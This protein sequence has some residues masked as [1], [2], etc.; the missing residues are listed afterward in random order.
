[1]KAQ[2]SHWRFLEL[3]S[4]Q[5]SARI[6]FFD[7]CVFNCNGS[8]SMASLYPVLTSVFWQVSK[9]GK[10]AWKVRKEALDE[11]EM[12]LKRVTGLVNASGSNLKHVI[13]LTRA[14]R[15]RL[16]DTQINLKPVA[17]RA[18]AGLLSMV[19]KTTQAKLGRIVFAP[20]INAAMN[21]I[22]KPM[23]DAALEALR[24]GTTA[25]ELLGGGINEEALE[26]FIAALV[27]EVTEA[28]ARVSY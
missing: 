9:E 28:S 12:A 18:I 10:T 16:S 5:L 21:D 6:V 3:K 19:D 15:D 17:A 11:V 20:L 24:S 26:P 27:G 2:V 13:D 23:R 1:V 14:L 4:L 7:W 25:S 22:K 8:G